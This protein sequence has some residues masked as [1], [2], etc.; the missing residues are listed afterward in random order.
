MKLVPP[1]ADK[2]AA[3]ADADLKTLKLST[4]LVD[5]SG[6]DRYLKFQRAYVEFLEPTKDRRPETLA[7]AHAHAADKSGAS[8]TEIGRLGALC[9][10]YAGRRLVE[11]T[12]EKKREQVRASI[13]AARSAGQ[14]A[15]ERDL[16]VEQRIAEQFQGGSAY[17]QLSKR[18]GRE[19]VDVLRTR[20]ADILELHQRQT[21][22]HV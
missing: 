14:K 20:E 19:A 1:N 22:V 15:S 17:D 9:T 5:D 12:L 6:L 21:A 18:Y 10:D 11:R 8:I 7:K 16:D 13:E 3:V 4:P 2:D